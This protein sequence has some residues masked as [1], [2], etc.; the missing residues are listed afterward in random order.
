MNE[1]IEFLMK[2]HEQVFEGIKLADQKAA[3]ITA[4]SVGT[5]YL[6]YE[7]MKAPCFVQWP[8]RFV[9]GLA[10]VFLLLGTGVALWAIHPPVGF[11]DRDV[12]GGTHTI[13]HR[14][15]KLSQADYVHWAVMATADD[16]ANEV[17]SLVYARMK[18]REWKYDRVQWAIGTMYVAYSLL[19][20]LVGHS[21][22]H[23]VRTRGA[24]RH[25]PKADQSGGSPV[26][27]GEQMAGAQPAGAIA[28][29]AI[30]DGKMAPTKVSES[31]ENLQPTGP[32]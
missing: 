9:G 27:S 7:L 4:I 23:T 19:L 16:R 13:P 3:A 32:A 14:A 18:I 6:L 15:V 28:G 30:L 20:L 24:A 2:Q 12:K 22:V 5:I 17:A 29:P 10:Q 26:T 31:G 21:I 11:A 8:W 1:T 25:S